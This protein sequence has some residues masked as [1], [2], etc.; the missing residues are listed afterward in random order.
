M[1]KTVSERIIV[2]ITG[3]SGAL[4]GVRSLRLLRGEGVRDPP[5]Y[6]RGGQAGHRT[7]DRLQGA[8][9]GGDGELHVR[10]QGSCRARGQRLISDRRHD[11]RPMHDEDPVRGRQLVRRQPDRAGRGCDAQ[12]K[13]QVG[14]RGPGNTPSQGPSPVDEPGGRHGGP[15]PAADSGLLSQTGHHRRHHRPDGWQ[16]T[17]FLWDRTRPV[18]TLGRKGRKEGKK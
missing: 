5:D 17:R 16:D 13:A 1:K 15:H 9:R 12:G 4:Y 7:G 10:R 8:G 14:A 3:A 6:L 2:G 11:H 18:Q